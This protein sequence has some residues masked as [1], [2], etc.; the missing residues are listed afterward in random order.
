MQVLTFIEGDTRP[1][2]V[3]KLYSGDVSGSAI[4]LSE[5]GTS[6]DLRLAKSGSSQ[7]VTIPMTVG[8]SPGLGE[9]IYDTSAGGTEE[10]GEFIGEVL[11]RF[12]DSTQQTA[13]SRFIFKILPKL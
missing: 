4:D 2:V 8:N 9:C 1:K 10:P 12:P 3:F 13:M 6:V 5:P 11:V 7:A